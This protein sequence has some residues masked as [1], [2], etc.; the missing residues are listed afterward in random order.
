MLR[1]DCE[2]GQADRPAIGL[3]VATVS[4]RRGND[5]V[6]VGNLAGYAIL[7]EAKDRQRRP[8]RPLKQEGHG[9][10]SLGN[11]TVTDQAKDPP[12]LSV[13]RK[14]GRRSCGT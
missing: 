3:H 6:R 12:R 8:L 10:G 11:R 14:D 9:T 7:G 13:E 2:L 1:R 5:E 4:P